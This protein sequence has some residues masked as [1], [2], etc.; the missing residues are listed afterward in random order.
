[1]N[2][3]QLT[4]RIPHAT[5]ITQPSMVRYLLNESFD[6]G[7]RFIGL[8]V[9][10]H[11]ATLF[12]N[13][14]FPCSL[15]TL[16]VVR[17][18]DTDD[19]MALFARHLDGDDLAI[20]GHLRS[21]FLIRLL[22]LRPQLKLSLDRHAD[23]LRS[24]KNDD[25]L[26]C[27]REAARIND[28]IL[29]TIKAQLKPGIRETEVADLIHAQHALH[30]VSASF[31]TSVAFGENAANPHAHPS[32][33]R[34]N[35]HEVILID[36]G[37]RYQGYCSDMTRCFYHGYVDLTLYNLVLKANQAAIK[38][39]RPGARFADVDAAARSVLTEAGYGDAFIHR[40]GHGIGQDIHEP[41]DVSASSNAVLEVGMVFTIEPGL[42][43]PG[44]T[45]LRLEDVVVVTPEGCQVLSQSPKDQ[46]ILL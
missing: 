26:S 11:R 23:A 16:D 29:T 33:R 42:Y 31:P 17:F 37:V 21:E 34:L 39:V 30:H 2:L 36:M 43:L 41:Y 1:M 40:T 22:A 6:V 44:K 4:R 32:D 7:E 13:R 5:L 19:V 35:P 10:P 38:A 18:D 25:E 9:T 3:S 46:P 12:L 20:D 28:A 15:T 45:G 14:L 8:L 24:V 27:L